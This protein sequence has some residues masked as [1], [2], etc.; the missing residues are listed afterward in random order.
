MTV[1][2]Q[3]LTN[4]QGT[5]KYIDQQGALQSLS[6]TTAHVPRILIGGTHFWGHADFYLAIPI[7]EATISKKNQTILSSIGVE[8][9]F[10]YYPWRL[11][12][13]KLRP[14]IGVAIT[15]FYYEQSNENIEFGSGPEL[16]RTLLPLTTGFAFNTRNHILELGM[17]WNYANEQDYYIS[18][19]QQQSVSAPELYFSL[20]YRYMFE[21][22]LSAEKDWESGKTAKTTEALALKRR[23]NGFYFGVGMSSAFW[24]GKSSYNSSERPYMAK[25]YSTSLM[26]ELNA[27][28]YLHKADINIGMSYRGYNT[29]TDTYGAEQQL[30]RRSLALEATKYLFDYHGFTPFIGPNASFENLKFEETFEGKAEDDVLENR[31]AYGL[32]F[33]WDIRPNRIQS[34]LLRT[35]LRWYPGLNLEVTNGK[36]VSFNT[37]EFNFIELI[38]YP[39]RM[40][41]RQPKNDSETK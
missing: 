35:N 32:T 38:I 25:R 15:P 36:S 28:Y 5:T 33:G 40:I 14:F 17:L 18:R 13:R 8:T 9:G 23:L 31:F 37:L 30:R 12:Q 11:E 19:T 10:K 26:P 24:I 34:W 29:S 1:G 22:T 16:N 4:T 2:I 20:S 7:Y 39:G 41:K 21:T 6:I 27:G 3:Y